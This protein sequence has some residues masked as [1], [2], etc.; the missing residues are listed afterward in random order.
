MRIC[1]TLGTPHRNSGQQR[2]TFLAH[3]DKSLA[4]VPA[5]KAYYPGAAERWQACTEGRSNMSTHGKAESDKVPWA[6]IKGLDP[7]SNET[8]YNNEPFCSVL[9][10]TTINTS[11][12]IEFLERAVEFVNKRL[13]G[14]LTANMIVH[15]QSMK[16][17][18]IAE[19][20]ERAITRLHYGTVTINGFN[21]MSFAFATP[22]WGGYPGSA[23]TDI[24][25]GQ[26]WVHNTSMLEGIEKAVIRFP[27]VSFPKPVWHPSHKTGHKL[28]PKVIELERHGSWSKVPGVVFTA[29]CG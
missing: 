11:D 1:G 4:A 21:G 17:P 29:M 7:H 16:D 12:T 3:I 23:L 20:V 13:W 28:V 9:T 24:Q 27:L 6:F 10:E 22:P 26:G 15:P 25:S 18:K 8:I 14:T 19:A 5:R 2:D